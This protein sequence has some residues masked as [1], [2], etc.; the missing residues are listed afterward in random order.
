MVKYFSTGYKAISVVL[1]TF[2][3]LIPAYTRSIHHPLVLFIMSYRLPTFFFTIIYALCLVVG[4]PVATSFNE[5]TIVNL[6]KRI[7]HN[8][9]VRPP[10]HLS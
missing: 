2:L 6:E 1:L 5:T 10:N 3:V 4:S 9:K 7:D 8:G